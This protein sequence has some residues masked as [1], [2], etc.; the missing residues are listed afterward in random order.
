[1]KIKSKYTHKDLD[2]QDYHPCYDQD[3]GDNLYDYVTQ[4][5]GEEF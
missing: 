5:M 4:N 3:S 1:M 2:N